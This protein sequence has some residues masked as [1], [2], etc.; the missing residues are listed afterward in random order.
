MLSRRTFLAAALAP[1]AVTAVGKAFDP[2]VRPAGKPLLKLG[3]AAYS[4]RQRLDLAKPTMTLLDFIDLAATMPLDGVELTSY[5][6]AETTAGYLKKLRERAAVKKLAISGVPVRSDFCLTDPAKLKAE[7]E[8][9]KTWTDHAADLGA[10]TVRIF[11]GNL[12]KGVTLES[13]Q[14][15]VVASIEE[16]CK[17]AE[18]RGVLLAL[19]NHGGITATPGQLLALVKPV[20]SKAFGV[21][22]DT[23]NFR[24]ADPYADVAAIAPYGVV[25]QLKTEVSPAGKPA[26]EADLARLIGIL[27]AANYHG[28]VVLEYEAKPD[29][30]LAVPKHIA[31]LRKLIDA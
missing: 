20:R 14:Q 3:L 18:K 23:G 26:E 8:H 7:V 27:R 10:A 17:H 4:Y 21:N 30:A 22:V 12:P 19:E 6:F 11:A 5:F 16:C 31:A 1:A 28:Y 15:R 29:P 24:T 9:V 25:V 2:V 13:A